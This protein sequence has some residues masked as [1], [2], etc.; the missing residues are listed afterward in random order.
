LQTTFIKILTKSIY[1][2]R[3]AKGG[4][5]KILKKY[6]EIFVSG[7]LIYEPTISKA[8]VIVQIYEKLHGNCRQNNSVRETVKMINTQSDVYFEKYLISSLIKPNTESE[9]ASL[10]RSTLTIASG[11]MVTM[12]L[13]RVWRGCAMA[14]KTCMCLLR[15]WWYALCP[16]GDG[17]VLVAGLVRVRHGR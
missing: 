4:K 2:F 10:K 13:L 9:S 16:L 1:V 12:H 8:I 14:P 3:L 5:S 11:S 6:K 7:L 15:L 17:R